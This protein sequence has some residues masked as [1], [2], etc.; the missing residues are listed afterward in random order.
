VGKKA[1]QEVRKKPASWQEDWGLRE[2]DS[3][4]GDTWE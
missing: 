1:F 3:F 4:L 2:R